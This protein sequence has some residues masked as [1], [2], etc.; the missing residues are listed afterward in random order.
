MVARSKNGSGLPFLRH[1]DL[2][3]VTAPLIDNTKS[4]LIGRATM[5]I[6]K[7]VSSL[8]VLA[9]TLIP[10]KLLRWHQ[11]F[12][13]KVP[14]SSWISNS[15]I[16][17]IKCSKLDSNCR[18]TLQF[19]SNYLIFIL[20]CLS[21]GVD[22]AE[23]GG[24][25]LSWYSTW[26]LNKW[27]PRSSWISQSKIPAKIQKSNFPEKSNCNNETS[28]FQSLELLGRWLCFD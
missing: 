17:A 12:Y 5:Y 9:K 20:R 4:F 8:C 3:T 22:C 14:K 24:E 21:L 13:K 26:A 25:G 10:L 19:H 28:S 18:R 27:E 15:K 11:I 1:K 6:E 7:L 23:I 2:D 16:P